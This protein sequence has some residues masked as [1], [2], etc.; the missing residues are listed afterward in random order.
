MDY[1][2]TFLSKC[3][4]TLEIS[5]LSHCTENWTG[6][7]IIS[8][9]NCIYLILDGEGEIILNHT[10]YFPKAGDV[11]IIPYGTHVSYHTINKN[12]YY[13]YW[14]HFQAVQAATHLFE[15][16]HVPFVF[17][18]ASTQNLEAQ[19]QSLTEAFQSASPFSP[20][21]ANGILC[22]LIAACLAEIPSSQLWIE[23]SSSIKT[24]HE[25]DA[26]ILENLH[27]T[28]TLKELAQQ[29]HF[30]PNYLIRF[31]NK[32]LFMSPMKYVSKMK[33]DRAKQLL[34]TSNLSISKIAMQLGYSSAYHFSNR[35][36]ETTGYTPSAWRDMHL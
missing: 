18:P 1:L 19:F 17:H 14:C 22:Q 31:F 36:K 11:V 27:R 15:F 12:G 28:I 5:A 24:I 21:L 30:H 13:K 23:Q 7:N 25:I 29:V 16:I 8:L 4:P 10:S 9:R 26:Y 2:S 6:T 20:L 32:H 3:I 33:I 35:F 34:V